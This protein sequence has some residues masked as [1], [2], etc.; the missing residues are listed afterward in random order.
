MLCSSGRS[1][2]APL[3]IAERLMVK[4]VKA[5]FGDF[6]NWEEIRGWTDEID[7]EMEDEMV[8]GLPQRGQTKMESFYLS[9]GGNDEDG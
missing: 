2:R 3:G 7:R 4:A 9:T 1:T 5:P 6:R 8:R